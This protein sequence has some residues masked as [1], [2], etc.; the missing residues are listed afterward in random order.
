MDKEA[1]ASFLADGVL[2]RILIRGQEKT[3]RVW[4]ED[5]NSSFF[6][7]YDFI[8]PNSD[9]IVGGEVIPADALESGIIKPEKINEV[10]TFLV[11]SFRLSKRQAVSVVT[12]A[13]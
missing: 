4:I 10:V 2:M 11:E 13:T 3:T 1:L 9:E 5:Y 6:L 7:H 8:G 12:T